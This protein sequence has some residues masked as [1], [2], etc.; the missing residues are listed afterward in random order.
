[1]KK[2]MKR[3]LSLL[4]S[5]A[6]ILGSAQMPSMRANAQENSV[7]VSTSENT[8][9][10]DYV[11]EEGTIPEFSQTKELDKAASNEPILEGYIEEYFDLGEVETSAIPFSPFTLTDGNVSLKN[12]TA[13]E[14]INRLDLT[15]DA[16]VIDEFYD[17][18]VEASDNDKTNDFLIEDS[19]FN[20]EGNYTIPVV[21]LTG[22]LHKTETY[23]EENA[24][25]AVNQEISKIFSA[26]AKYI[27][28]AYDAFDRD[29]PEVFWLSG[30]TV[31]GNQCSYSAAVGTGEY[32]ITYTLTIHFLL[33]GTAQG[34][35]F[36][37]R[38]D[39]YRSE[40]SITD[41]ISAVKTRVNELVNAVPDK[42]IAEKITYFNEQLTKT[43]Q[44][45]TSKDL[46]AIGHD[47]RECTAALAGKTG[48]D[49]PVCESY[50]R[51]FKILCDKVGIPCVL[52]DGQAKT[53]KTSN[54][55][56]HMWNYVR[57][58]DKWLAVDV[59]WNDPLSGKNEAISGCENEDWLMVYR[60]SL[61]SN[62]MTFLE[63]HPVENRASQDGIS[64]TN[65]PELA[66]SDIRADSTRMFL[67]HL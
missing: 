29:H 7:V 9:P 17:T 44:Y 27:R 16:Q 10:D 24:N 33:K 59:T 58:D 52:V 3:G 45:N 31:A 1:M 41:G 40:K 21:E 65:G 37:I 11:G 13:T 64:F 23:S 55:E 43:N 46:N 32:T 19:Y 14:W 49:G 67:T 18:L 22:T 38:A 42:S 48:T 5:L 66:M 51:A 2:G 60:D 36:D 62:G 57:V 8:L 25:A 6:M 4:L 35:P 47:C 53:S 15:G 56:P 39:V 30:D 20:S 54:G 12:G 34:K 61:M 50:A 28:A 63:S 26:Y